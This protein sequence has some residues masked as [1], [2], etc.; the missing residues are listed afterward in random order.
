MPHKMRQALDCLASSQLWEAQ[1][2][3]VA[4]CDFALVSRDVNKFQAHTGP[5]GDETP[6]EGDGISYPRTTD[7]TRTPLGCDGE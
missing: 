4:L 2:P 5:R 3:R 6:E 7:G 1:L